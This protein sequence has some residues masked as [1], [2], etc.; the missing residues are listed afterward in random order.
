MADIVII[1]ANVLPSQN[2]QPTQGVAGET[3]VQGD[4]LYLDTATRAYKKAQANGASPANTVA[5][6]AVTGGSLNQP[7]LLVQKDPNF[8]V[9]GTV[10][11]GETIVLSDT[12]G[13][14]CPDADPVSGSTKI[15][16][17]IGL[18]GNH[19]IFSPLVGGAVP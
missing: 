14:M 1:P 3:I 10:A 17:G 11:P 5:G 6:V 7:L 12:P 15:V 4:V 16:L 19:M 8:L 9:G 18:P 13:K 2:V